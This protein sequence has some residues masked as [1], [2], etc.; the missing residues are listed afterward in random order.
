M[1]FI[2]EKNNRNKIEICKAL[3]FIKNNEV[4]SLIKLSQEL[5][6]S[7]VT[8]RNLVKEINKD[9]G[10]N[11]HIIIQNNQAILN[12]NNYTIEQIVNFYSSHD[13]GYKILESLLIKP[14]VYSVT[15]LAQNLFVSRPH[16]Y[17]IIKYF[18][19]HL[20]P[21]NI[22]ITLDDGI[23]LVGTEKTIKNLLFELISLSNDPV[24]KLSI[25]PGDSLLRRQVNIIFAEYSM[26]PS[27][28]NVH[29]FG[30][31]IL[32]CLNWRYILRKKKYNYP[33]RK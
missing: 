6:I 2:L 17:K 23:R 30:N 20:L 5:R 33:R 12:K 18:N 9:F 26:I 21:Y 22:S 25:H 28:F 10:D 29:S 7:S 14:S 1:I 15:Q 3:L 8:I 32:T 11:I 19:E 13:I 27:F 16:L 24:E 4:I 31:W